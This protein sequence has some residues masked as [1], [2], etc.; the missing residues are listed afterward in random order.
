MHAVNADLNMQTGRHQE[1]TQRRPAASPGSV[2]CGINQL[3]HRDRRLTSLFISVG[4]QSTLGGG[5]KIF[6]RKIYM[7]N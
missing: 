1:W 7:K 5:D 4:A 2:H 3:G 6:A